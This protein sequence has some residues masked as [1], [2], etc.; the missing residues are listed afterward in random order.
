M[1][2]SNIRNLSLRAQRFFLKLLSKEYNFT[3]VFLVCAKICM[4]KKNQ[5]I[6]VADFSVDF[7]HK[8]FSPFNGVG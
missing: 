5:L 3:Q 2:Q 1:M 4:L 6:D 7:L 8:C